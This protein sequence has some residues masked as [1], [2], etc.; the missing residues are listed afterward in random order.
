MSDRAELHTL[1]RF[2]D[3]AGALL[4][5]GRTCNP[6]QRFGDH[7]R[8]K[9]WW[10][11]VVRIDMEQHADAG[12]LCTAERA[13]IKTETP[14]HNIAM[15]GNA[16]SPLEETGGAETRAAEHCDGIIGRWFHS[17]EPTDDEDDPLAYPAPKG[18]R[19][20]WQGQVVDSDDRFYV[21]Q[22]YSWWDGCPNG[23]KLVEA[24]E[25]KDWTFYSSAEQMQMSVGCRES[26]GDW[27]CRKP[28]THR[29][30]LGYCCGS[31]ARFYSDAKEVAA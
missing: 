25:L 16:P 13:A 27:V 24:T 5:V 19:I 29:T 26:R 7:R 12:A 23:Q 4:Y 10:A 17:F 28:A 8:S 9:T 2:F 11:S 20:R 30:S 21:V 3:Q 15:N 14:L 31:C 22:L 6:G 1:Y 18:M